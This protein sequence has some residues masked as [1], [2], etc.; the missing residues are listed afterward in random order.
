MAPM[1]R[2][3]EK[4]ACPSAARTTEPSTFEKSGHSVR[5][6]NRSAPLVAAISVAA[7]SNPIAAWARDERPDVHVQVAVDAAQGLLGATVF[8]LRKELLSNEPSAHL[9]VIVLAPQAEGN[10]VGTAL[11]EAAEH[12][13]QGLGAQSMTLHV[14]ASNTRAVRLYERLGYDGELIRYIKTL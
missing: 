10:G 5:T 3:S 8:S 4:K 2:L 12:K 11:L 1:P 13:A 7:S 9:E 6:S 14:F